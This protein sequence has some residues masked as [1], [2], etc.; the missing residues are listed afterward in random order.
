MSK[1]WWF[2]V[3]FVAACVQGGE[4]FTVA[5][6][7]VE[8]YFLTPFG[9][10]KAKSEA[11]RAKVAEVIARIR[12]DVLALQE[13]G[14][15]AAL[16][17]LEGRLDRVGLRFPHQVWVDGP[18][19][20]IHLV[21]L[22]RFTIVT[23]RSKGRVDYLLDQRRFQM[24]R[25]VAEVVIQVNEQYRF[26]LF[27]IHLKSKR[28]VAVADQAAMRLEEARQLRQ[29]VAARLQ[30]EPDANLLVVGDLN[31]TPNTDPIREIVGR[32]GPRLMDLRPVEDNGDSA[33]HPY[34]PR[35]SPRRVAW[36]HFYHVKDEYS[37][38]DYTLASRGKFR[39][40]DASGCRVQAMRDWGVAS[41]HR[42]VVVRFFAEDR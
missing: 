22:S 29:R 39:E 24:S 34:N 10:R 41:D 25:G 28:P 30:A 17:E 1:R 40:M 3:I 35:S 26:I 31:D 27:N 5:T 6:F 18:D 23:N 21:V 4:T 12:P 14:R 42:P 15:P 11:S 32:R 36:T 19:P 37:W 13:M 38:L 7:N 16:K 33:P 20:A 2:G 9:T 8:N